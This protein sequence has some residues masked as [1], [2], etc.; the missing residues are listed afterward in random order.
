MLSSFGSSFSTFH[1]NDMQ[2]PTSNVIHPDEET[3]EL[4]QFCSSA[5]IESSDSRDMGIKFE[6]KA[7][8]VSNWSSKSSAR[9]TS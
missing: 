6:E 7:G 8:Y 3:E 1:S 5:D 4:L 9:D 2:E